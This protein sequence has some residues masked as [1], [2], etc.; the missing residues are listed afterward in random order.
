MSLVTFHGLVN[1][2]RQ[3]FDGCE[4]LVTFTVP[5]YYYV[6]S[7]SVR[8]SRVPINEHREFSCATEIYYYVTEIS[9]CKLRIWS[10]K[11]NST[12]SLTHESIN[13]VQSDSTGNNGLVTSWPMHRKHKSILCRISH[14]ILFTIA[15]PTTHHSSPSIM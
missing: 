9:I 3:D 5:T 4:I 14:S 10:E 12:A 6:V 11:T 15:S 13:I 7:T 1:L 8:I 2:L